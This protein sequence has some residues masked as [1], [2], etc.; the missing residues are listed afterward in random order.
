MPIFFRE[1][2]GG[3]VRA[4]SRGR[5]E[6]GRAWEIADLP[7]RLALGGAMLFHGL[8]KVRAP[9]GAAP[10]FEGLGLRPGRRWVLA[11]GWAETFAGA[12]AIL[13]IATRPAALAIFAT[14]LVAIWKVHA[15][16]GYENMKGGMEYNLALLS[17]AAG[18]ALESPRRWSAHRALRGTPRARRLGRFG[19][20]APRALARALDV[21]H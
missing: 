19:A 12:A 8:Q 17:L 1:G 3:T 6:E 14:Q 13:G 18:L 10:F 20:R 7:A 11:A 9:D 5:R 15:P 16:K 2:A 21:M 4:A